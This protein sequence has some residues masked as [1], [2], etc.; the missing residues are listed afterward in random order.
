MN[1]AYGNI[2]AAGTFTDQIG[3]GNWMWVLNN[4]TEPYGSQIFMTIDF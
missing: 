4:L 1:F 3:S 2:F